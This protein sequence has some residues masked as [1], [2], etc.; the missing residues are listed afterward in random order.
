MINVMELPH[1]LLR[2]VRKKI[3][4]IIM[5][6]SLLFLIT[7]QSLYA[8]DNTQ[9]GFTAA[10]PDWK[11]GDINRFPQRLL[12]LLDTSG[13][14]VK[15][16]RRYGAEPGLRY[17]QGVFGE[18]IQEWLEDLRKSGK[19][20]LYLDK[21]YISHVL[22]YGFK[23]DGGSWKSDFLYFPMKSSPGQ[24]PFDLLKSYGTPFIAEDIYRRHWG[25]AS[26]SK[27]LA[28]AILADSIKEFKGE[29]GQMPLSQSLYLLNITDNKNNRN[30]KN[31]ELTEVKAAEGIVTRLGS[32]LQGFDYLWKNIEKSNV[33]YNYLQ[34]A[35]YALFEH[36][37]TKAYEQDVNRIFSKDCKGD[38]EN[39][40]VASLAQVTPAIPLNP[41]NFFI[42]NEAIQF[43]IT[44]EGYHSDISF[45][46][47]N[48]EKDYYTLQ[49]LCIS[50][51]G[52]SIRKA[53]EYEPKTNEPITF[54]VDL[55]KSEI[56]EERP[57]KLEVSS[58]FRY[59]PEGFDLGLVI[60]KIQEFSIAYQAP[61][62]LANGS[63]LTP[64]VMRD[65]PEKT[66]EEILIHFEA[67]EHKKNL[68][69]LIIAIIAVAFSVSTLG[70]LLY[71]WLNRF[72]A[73]ILKHSISTRGEKNNEDD[74][75]GDEENNN[76]NSILRDVNIALEDYRNI[77]EIVVGSYALENTSGKN[78]F[79][80]YEQLRLTKL[81]IE[82]SDLVPGG[83]ADSALLMIGNS[84][85]YQDLPLIH[86]A[87]WP[88]IIDLRKLTQ[89]D[90]ID[91]P[92][93]WLKI[94]G[95]IQYRLDH[96]RLHGVQQ[97]DSYF[98]V[99]VNIQPAE[100]RFSP[101]I[102][103]NS[104]NTEG[105]E[106]DLDRGEAL[107]GSFVLRDKTFARFRT[108]ADLKVTGVM[109]RVATTGKVICNE[110]VFHL[111]LAGLPGFQDSA[112]RKTSSLGIGIGNEIIIGDVEFALKLDMK[113]LDP[114][115]R[116]TEFELELNVENERDG[117]SLQKREN[118]FIFENQKEA[119][120]VVSYIGFLSLSSNQQLIYEPGE[121]LDFRDGAPAVQDESLRESI[122]NFKLYNSAT[123][124]NGDVPTNIV[125]ILN[126][127]LQDQKTGRD[128]F[129]LLKG[130]H[131][132]ENIA[133]KEKPLNIELQPIKGNEFEISV[134]VNKQVESAFFETGEVHAR[135][136]IE[137]EYF[138]KN[139]MKDLPASLEIPF[140]FNV[141]PDLGKEVVAVDFGTCAIASAHSIIKDNEPVHEVVPMK[142]YWAKCHDLRT[143]PRER[144]DSLISSMLYL[145]ESRNLELS[146]PSIL[147]VS[148]PNTYEMPFLKSFIGGCLQSYPLPDG[149]SYALGDAVKFA[150]EVLHKDYFSKHRKNKSYKRMV[151]T[152]PNSYM[153]GQ[154][155][156]LKKKIKAVTPEVYE[157]Q[158]IS[159]S[160]AVIYEYLRNRH[161]YE[162]APEIKAGEYENILCFDMGAGT[163]D[164][165]F[166]S[167]PY[168]ED[169][170]GNLYPDFYGEHTGRLM[171]MVSVTGAGNYLD[172]LLARMIDRHL[173]EIVARFRQLKEENTEDIK[174]NLLDAYP[175]F[176][177][178][179]NREDI[180]NQR[181]ALEKLHDAIQNAKADLANDTNTL[182]V[183][184]PWSFDV[185]E[186]SFMHIDRK[187]YD[188]LKAKMGDDLK[189]RLED[190]NVFLEIKMT[191][192]NQY[193]EENYFPGQILE[194]LDAILKSDQGNSERINT[195]LISGRGSLFPGIREKIKE[196]VTKYNQG[197]E[198]KIIF[199]KNPGKMKY[200]VAEGALKWGM[201]AMAGESLF[202]T[203]IVHGTIGIAY[204]FGNKWKWSELIKGQE[205]DRNDPTRTPVQD[206]FIT[207][208]TCQLILVLLTT[209]NSPGMVEEFLKNIEYES[210]NTLRRNL[211]SKGYFRVLYFN[212]NPGSLRKYGKVSFELLPLTIED[213][214][215]LYGEHDFSTS[216]ENIRIQVSIE[217]KTGQKV[218]L[219][220][221][222]A[223][224]GT[225][226]TYNDTWPA[227]VFRDVED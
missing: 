22:G 178:V 212:E 142:R 211:E 9:F 24:S 106:F 45:N 33:Y 193:L 76:N 21:P 194:P 51:K 227:K 172:E 191:D 164:L 150:Y 25:L 202:D 26:A 127:E 52:K 204:L 28:L 5:L 182:T 166:R 206:A 95:K 112:V 59:K 98:S 129:I 15:T 180:V 3:Y 79:G 41:S 188:I 71:K 68:I 140:I 128:N 69:R 161:M 167:I 62:R 221:K 179:E 154:I 35:E 197:S 195:V 64:K 77:P 94:Q 48:T 124:P 141:K 121:I 18:R 203:P 44:A 55:D 185:K 155:E 96:H 222:E 2:M 67:E 217:G 93:G 36:S 219:K 200:I 135:L 80:H 23:T 209:I 60:E 216:F 198:P 97:E 50:L 207:P 107:L 192:V 109:Y 132:I 103:M 169:E 39:S 157:I 42:P 153:D 190:R 175:C 85:D 213:G 83:E 210:L 82:I 126:I 105:I 12:I 148:K 10:S 86:K 43:K 156:Y 91:F 171:G 201:D 177:K 214:P 4:F 19:V 149:K 130:K 143:D 40:L 118:F 73:P 183:E 88:V 152:H 218:V 224:I 122:L 47:L 1:I 78:R 14:V 114:I 215:D 81:F 89:I 102:I 92:D 38:C 225:P 54:S 189:L 136:N 163:V 173:Q 165:S 75:S 56:K 27:P 168:K 125:R 99:Q 84:T 65:N 49:K 117:S 181:R 7:G 34:Q 196:H 11:K 8:I 17:W 72:P 176:E 184:L 226:L 220:T 199:Q 100:Y 205:I 144:D 31:P 111:E 110:N 16:V 115:Y 123:H 133:L 139:E 186:L 108:P 187:T 208:Q 6:L 87:Q 46:I 104:E 159:E 37:S 113:N 151:I 57:S 32:N 138:D 74:Y 63:F 53:C 58:I 162:D 101:E 134:E 119:R 20:Q 70:Y 61:P 66:Q 158:S 29:K 120:L 146:P 13:S 223:S 145:D 90:R 30:I 160:D 116:K 131:G 174:A 147:G 170:Q 137:Y